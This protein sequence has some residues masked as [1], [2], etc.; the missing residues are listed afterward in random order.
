[1]RKTV[2]A[3]GALSM[4]A[5]LTFAAPAQAGGSTTTAITTTTTRGCPCC[6]ACPAS[7]WTCG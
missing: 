7:P 6:T 1:M 2:Y 3:A 4:L 5:A